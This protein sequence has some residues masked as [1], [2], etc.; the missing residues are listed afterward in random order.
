MN[1]T[2]GY[3]QSDWK[4]KIK[5][6]LEEHNLDEF[7]LNLD[8]YKSTLETEKTIKKVNECRTYILNHWD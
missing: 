1:R 4:D 7:T 8:T 5:E 3:K 2:F 6:A